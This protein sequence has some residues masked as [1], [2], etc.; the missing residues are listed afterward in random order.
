MKDSARIT[1]IARWH[2]LFGLCF[3]VIGLALGCYMGASENHGQLVTHAHVML[4]GFVVSAL[5]AVVYRLWLPATGTKLAIVQTVLHELG[6]VVLTGGLFLM[7][8]G[9]ATEAA[10]GPVLGVAS[11]VALAGACVML[12]QVA[13]V[14]REA[15]APAHDSMV[16][17][18][19]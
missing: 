13:R 17:G 4:L 2:L 14:G 7:F 9:Y 6:T 11:V 1:Q 18:R 5:Y 15:G 12:Y 3:A 8:G 19:A 16:A 10:L